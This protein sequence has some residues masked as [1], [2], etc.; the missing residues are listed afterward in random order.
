MESDVPGDGAE[1]DEEGPTS[2]QLSD[3]VAAASS[4]LAAGGGKVSQGHGSRQLQD[5][6][7][8]TFTAS[9]QPSGS[10]LQP[11]C[12]QH[13]HFSHRVRCF[14]HSPCVAL[15]ALKLSVAN[16]CISQHAASQR[17]C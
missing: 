11:V 1:V 10:T 14:S 8:H 5:F 2:E 3:I 16:D 12:I 17:F 4:V 15:H 13:Q 7:M 6:T 9:K